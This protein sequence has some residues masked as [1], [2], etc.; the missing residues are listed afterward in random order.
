MGM[1]L[2]LQRGGI[3]R[4][5]SQTLSKTLLK[6]IKEEEKG[7]ARRRFWGGIERSALKLS[8]SFLF[9]SL[10]LSFSSIFR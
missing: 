10:F 4:I 3:H 8:I 1:N 7:E 9:F 5:G 2:A 6:K